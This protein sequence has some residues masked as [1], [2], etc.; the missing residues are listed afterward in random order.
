M[1]GLVPESEVVV[2]YH[3][4]HE[5]Y[6]ASIM[7]RGLRAGRT[8]E[9]GWDDPV[10]VYLFGEEGEA[11]WF[12][13]G[14]G[15]DTI[16]EVDVSGFEGE[17]DPDM[18]SGSLALGGPDYVSAFRVRSSIGPE[19]ILDSYPSFLAEKK[20]VGFDGDGFPLDPAYDGS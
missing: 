3:A 15:R 7:A 9:C 19:W 13:N 6:I 4:T 14:W 12:C 20:R 10:A 1:A 11:A 2:G 17:S 16:V 5:M 18:A 8:E